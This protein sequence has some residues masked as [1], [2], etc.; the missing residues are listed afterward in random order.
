M[1][2]LLPRIIIVM[3]V[4]TSLNKPNSFIHST[5]I[6][7]DDK[8]TSNLCCP[9]YLVFDA[10]SLSSYWEVLFGSMFKL[11]ICSFHTVIL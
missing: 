6:E 9:G 3:L 1:E 7:N 11:S 8:C 4:I 5:T 10:V 2:H